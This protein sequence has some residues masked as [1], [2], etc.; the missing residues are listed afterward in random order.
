MI[1]NAVTLTVVRV[2]FRP[3]ILP[4]NVS[5]QY[6]NRH[7]LG[8]G[9]LVN[10]IQSPPEPIVSWDCS[11]G[12]T[13]RALSMNV[14]YQCPFLGMQNPLKARL[15][16]VAYM[17]LLSVL[18]PEDI[19][20]INARLRTYG[21]EVGHAG[22]VGVVQQFQVLPL[23]VSFS[24]IAVEEVPCVRG[25]ATGY[26]RHAIPSNCWTHTRAAG[27]GKWYN[28]HIDNVVGGLESSEDEAALT[29]ELLPMTAD[30]VLT[31]DVRIGWLEGDMNWEI[32]F[33]WNVK[34]T[35]GVVAPL[36]QFATN[37]VQSFIITPSGECGVRKFHNQAQRDLNDRRRFN[38]R[39]VTDNEVRI[40]D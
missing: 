7:T 26:F 31:N 15:P 32:P 37:T 27:A 5:Y 4:P 17:P 21:L 18:E 8:I 14:V 30:G 3:R 34:G 11:A 24:E 1:V 25:G 38:G 13:I 29:K 12:G 36:G 22:G 20:P 39:I 6:G 19:L 16:G 28:V 2:S 23:F 33:G 10:L 35:A 9:E 40:G